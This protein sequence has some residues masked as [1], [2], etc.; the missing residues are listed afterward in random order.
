MEVVVP[1]SSNFTI[2]R[3]EPKKICY[4]SDDGVI[5]IDAKVNDGSDYQYAWSNNATTKNIDNLKAGTYS[6][7]VTAT[8]KEQYT[9]EET[10]TFEVEQY[11]PIMFSVS[12][13]I[14][15]SCYNSADGV[16]SLANLRGGNNTYRRFEFFDLAGKQL[17]DSIPSTFADTTATL[18][19]SGLLAAGEYKVVVTDGDLNC[20]SDSVS[21]KVYSATPKIE[22]AE[23][24]DDEPLCY[25]YDKN[26]KLSYGKITVD[27]RAITT[28]QVSS[29]T[30]DLA[31]F[32]K[33][34]G[35]DSQTAHIFS[36]VTAGQHT[37]TVGFGDKQD[38]P[39]EIEHELKSKN[40]LKANAAFRNNQKVI[41]TCPDNLLSA[42]VTA[43]N[44]FNTFKFYTMYNE[45]AENYGK[46][47]EVEPQPADT[48]ADATA[49]RFNRGIYYRADSLGGVDS[50][51]TEPVVEEIVYNHG[52]DIRGNQITL[53]AE[54]NGS[55]GKV[56]ADDFMPYGRETFYYFEIADNQCASIDSIRAVAMFADEKLKAV[57]SMEDATSDDLLINGEYEV[58]EGAPLILTAD[59]LKFTPE[60]VYVYS[61]SSWLW[62]S[63]PADHNEGSGLRPES[64]LTENTIVAQAYG[65]L[66][67]KVRDSVAFELNDLVYNVDTTMV[68]YYYDSVI[69]NSISGIRPADVVLVGSVGKHNKWRIE[70]LA[71]YDKVTIY[72][73]NRW[74]GRVW[75]Y[76][77]SGKEYSDAH[78]WNGRNEK[79]KP[80]PSGTYYYVIQ[81]SDGILGGK[82]VTGP[83]T[84]IR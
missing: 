28:A 46:V 5:T 67:A 77:G 64:T 8:V 1:D 59:Q 65:R 16:V 68:C 39:V 60:N 62:A 73:F 33:L 38:C 47:K 22:I 27:A 53:F 2:K 13:S 40:N 17:F 75:Q 37:I 18:S 25:E 3:I 19:F 50:T 12:N 45:D 14:V 32:Y 49:Y 24:I 66:Y 83:V 55:E 61:E 26:G 9:C 54:G 70:G 41:F 48:A 30:T 23:L 69:V 72:V 11:A 4:G 56:W 42:Y 63:A 21:L 29:T 34:D 80:V 15:N 10:E 57:V 76:S 81:C 44:K 43:D 31:V 35:G 71:S 78:E 51:I 58:A 20:H 84:V 6:V 74:G 82:K 7:T 52:T 36:N 79:N